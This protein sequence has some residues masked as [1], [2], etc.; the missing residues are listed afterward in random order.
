MRE[1]TIMYQI[2]RFNKFA[3]YKINYKKS[4]MFLYTKNEISAKEKN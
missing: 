4:V 2:K 1:G 3:G